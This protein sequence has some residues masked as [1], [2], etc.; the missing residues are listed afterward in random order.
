MIRLENL[1]KTES[2]HIEKVN[3]MRRNGEEPDEMRVK[4]L[5]NTRNEIEEIKNMRSVGKRI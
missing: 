2:R 1:I 3:E 5:T 4:L